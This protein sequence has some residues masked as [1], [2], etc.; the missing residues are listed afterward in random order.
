MMRRDRVS[1]GASR[2]LKS[3]Q[4][5]DLFCHKPPDP[6]QGRLS[7]SVAVTLVEPVGGLMILFTRVDVDDCAGAKIERIFLSIDGV[8]V[9]PFGNG[10]VECDFVSGLKFFENQKI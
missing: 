8:L 2:G 3:P 5:D 10:K 1:R 9:A 7:R 4:W 6:S